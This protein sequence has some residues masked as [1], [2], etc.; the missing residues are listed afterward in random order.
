MRNIVVLPLPL[1]PSSPKQFGVADV[2]R[3]PVQRSPAVITVDQILNRDHNRSGKRG[4]TLGVKRDVSGGFGDHRV[5]YLKRAARL[6]SVGPDFPNPLRIRALRH[7]SAGRVR[8]RP[9]TSNVGLQ[10]RV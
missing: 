8:A 10:M 6:R 7:R 2:K 4:A 9:H 5:F 1:G 3:N